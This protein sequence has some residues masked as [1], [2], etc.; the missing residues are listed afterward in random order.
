MLSRIKHRHDPF[1]VFDSE[2]G[3][4]LAKCLYETYV[5]WRDASADLRTKVWPACDRA[6]LSIRTLPR[7][8]GFHWVDKGDLGETDVWDAVRMIMEGLLLSLMPRDESWLSPV[9]Y[10]TEK[11]S[12]QNLVRDYLITKHREGDLS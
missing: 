7:A 11:Q 9:A 3:K 10:E 2:E 1:P 8:P 4:E 6:F 5:D 12:A